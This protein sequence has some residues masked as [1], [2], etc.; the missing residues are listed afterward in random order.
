MKDLKSKG[1]K[2]FV[3]DFLGKLATQGTG[4]I[5]TIFLARLLEPSDFG[6]IAMLMVVVGVAQVFTDVGLGGALIQ[7]RK[8]L[9]VHYSSVFYF[10]ISIGTLLT[11][12]T[13][14]SAKFI[15]DF[16]DD[17]AL[18]PLMQAISFLFIINSFSSVQAIRLRKQLNY[19]LLTKV[20]F[21]SSLLSGIVGVILAFNGAG[22]WSLVAQVISQGLFYNLMLWKV[23]D[24]LPSLSFSFKALK[25]LWGFGFRMFLVGLIEA[26]STKLDFLIIGKLFPVSTLGY[27]QR[28]KSLNALVIQYTSGSLMSVLF[29]LLSQVQSDLFRLREIIIQCLNILTFTVFILIGCLYLSSEE[30][31]VF[32]FSDKWLPSVPYVELLMISA[33]AFPINALLVNV[34]S[35]RGNSKSFL[36]MSVVKKTIF[37]A[38][39]GLAF[40]WGIEGYLIG[41]IIVSLINT[42][43]TIYFISREVTVPYMLL[44]KPIVFQM[45][46]S[47]SAL[48]PVIFLSNLLMLHYFVGFIF[49]T[50]VFVLFFIGLNFLFKT[51]SWFS[52][53][54]QISPFYKKYSKRN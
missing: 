36:K 27:F 40:N 37:F 31:I 23:T 46:I 1:I 7:R 43:I 48:L 30:V 15:A 44:L 26:V 41:L 4:F 3:W 53:V 24:W 8:L 50:S 10:N 12:I 20:S 35:S 13:F 39:L 11:C 16:Y 52:V 9:E 14:F 25:Q 28:A 18:I 51:D 19:A 2:A 17:Q 6:L 5:V 42:S 47:L 22:V 34:L 33:F 49:K 54:Q 38:N 32:L 29:P 21:V 45:A